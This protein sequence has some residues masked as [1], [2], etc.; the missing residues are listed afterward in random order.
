MKI[1]K[2]FLIDSIN[3]LSENTY[4]VI[5]PKIYYFDNT[6]QKSIKNFPKPINLFIEV[7]LFL[8][9]LKIILTNTMN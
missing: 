3:F 1:K 4:S 5:C 9:L 7:Y 8:N 6:V 2:N